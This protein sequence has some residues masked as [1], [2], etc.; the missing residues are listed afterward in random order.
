[1]QYAPKQLNPKKALLKDQFQSKLKK[2]LSLVEVNGVNIPNS[3][4]GPLRMVT[5]GYFGINN[6]KHVGKLAFTA[7]ES[8]EIYEIKLQNFTNWKERIAYPSVKMPVKSWIV[9]PLK[10][11]NLVTS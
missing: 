4:G 1:M 9:S 8:S 3:H 5:P 10:V 6:V 2:M 7:K 11:Q